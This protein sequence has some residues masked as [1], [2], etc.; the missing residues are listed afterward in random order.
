[1]T[2]GNQPTGSIDGWARVLALLLTAWEP[3]SF[4]I[5]A[6][7]AFN[8]MAVR[9]VP[10]A[11]VVLARL[12]TTALCVAAGR[13]LLDRRPIAPGLTRAALILAACVQVFADVTPYF[14]SNRLPGQTPLYVGWTVV[15]YAGWLLYVQRSR[16]FA[17]LFG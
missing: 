2:T 13:A 9:G 8:A 16:R 6:A 7:G 11:L 14:P 4:A 1:V 10:V 3:L 5:A 15:Y 17:A 12:A